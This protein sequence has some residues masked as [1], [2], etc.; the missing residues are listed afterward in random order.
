MP[1]TFKKKKKK[2]LW[3]GISNPC[4]ASSAGWAHAPLIAELSAWDSV[5]QHDEQHNDYPHVRDRCI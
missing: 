4:T 3:H 2:K 1:P 5:P